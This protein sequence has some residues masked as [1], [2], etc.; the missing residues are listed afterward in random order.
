M[1]IAGV[2]VGMNLLLLLQYQLFMKGLHQIAAYPHGWFDLWV[3]RFLVP[4]RI[5]AWWLR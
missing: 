5:V 2:L 4:F 3:T 1:A